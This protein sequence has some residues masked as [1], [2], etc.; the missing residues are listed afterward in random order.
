MSLLDFHW[1]DNELVTRWSFFND[2]S[3]K[4]RAISLYAYDQDG[5]RVTSEWPIMSGPIL[6][7]GEREEKTM[8]WK[9][10][11]RSVEITITVTEDAKWDYKETIPTAERHFI[12]TR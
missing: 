8:T 3:Q 1:E 9:C 4:N 2:R 6:W 11:P 10:G 5:N 12:I 7:S